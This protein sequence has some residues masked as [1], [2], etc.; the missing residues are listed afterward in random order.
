MSA[1]SFDNGLSGISRISSDVI[2]KD[3]PKSKSSMKPS[4]EHVPAHFWK[5]LDMHRTFKNREFR[6]A[7]NVSGQHVSLT[8]EEHY[9]M[10]ARMISYLKKLIAFNQKKK[11]SKGKPKNLDAI[12][13]A[14]AIFE[15]SQAFQEELMM[16]RNVLLPG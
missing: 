12:A 15:E 8:P 1:I 16:S 2:D 6:F 11:N 5:V 3:F 14:L 4:G 7:T 9:M 10:T 13:A